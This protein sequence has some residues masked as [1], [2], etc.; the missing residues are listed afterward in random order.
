MQFL[1]DEVILVAMEDDLKGRSIVR[2]G[3][4][5]EWKYFSGSDSLI[6]T[7][8]GSGTDWESQE[9]MVSLGGKRRRRGPKCLY[10]DLDRSR[11]EAETNSKSHF[12][13]NAMIL[14]GGP[15]GWTPACSSSTLHDQGLPC[16][17]FVFV[18]PN[19]KGWAVMSLSEGDMMMSTFCHTFICVL[20]LLFQPVAIRSTQCMKP[21]ALEPRWHR[22]PRRAALEVDLIHPNGTL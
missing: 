9:R 13:Y 18:S 17:F 15:C 11:E 5:R 6:V 21:S 2:L 20:P 4:R 7:S 3:A 22:K 16:L 14:H 19:M 10:T 1:T 12:Y 8:G